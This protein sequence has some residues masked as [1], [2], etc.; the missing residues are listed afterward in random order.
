MKDLRAAKGVFDESVSTVKARIMASSHSA[1][2]LPDFLEWFGHI[3]A[4]KDLPLDP[5]PQILTGYVEWAQKARGYYL[6]FLQA[7]FSAK[8]RPLPGWIRIILKLGRY[9]IASKALVQFASEFPALLNSMT[10]KPVIAPSRT[11]F[12]IPEDEVPLTSVLRRVVGPR[13]PEYLSRLARVWNTPDVESYFRRACP[14]NLVVHAEMQLVNFYDHNRQCKPSFRFIG[15]S[16]KSCYLCH[17]FLATHPESFCISSCHQKLYLPWI[18]PPATHSSIYRRYKAITNE[19]SKLME[20]AAKHDMENRLGG[21]RRPVPPDST[22]GVSLS[23]L[24]DVLGMGSQ[25][26]LQSQADFYISSDTVM[27]GNSAIGSNIRGE[28]ETFESPS[29]LYPIDVVELTPPDMDMEPVILDTGDVAINKN[30]STSVLAIVFHFIQA[31]DLDKQ[32]IVS[33]RDV[34]DPSTNRPSWVKLLEILKAD[35]DFGI[36]FQEGQQ[37]LVV[38]DQ[39]RVS[40]ERQF[41][42][43]LQYL[44]NS[45]VLNSEALVRNI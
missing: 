9:G 39:I 14:L 37:V 6:D 23:G 1:S 20:A 4:I 26:L 28:E 27:E 35:D 7:A 19:L 30:N 44:L 34:F 17:M 5:E 18:P 11:P 33:M 29:S 12:T 41:L 24:T 2:A 38:N 8:L 15:V 16:K 32:D 31:D 42:A 22:A 40:N 25:V 10:V 36:T 3:F 21:E 43:C 13:T 45:N